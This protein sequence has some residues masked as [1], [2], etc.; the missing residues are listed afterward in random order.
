[1]LLVASFDSGY[2]LKIEPQKLDWILGVLESE[3][4]LGLPELLGQVV[5]QPPYDCLMMP[6][7]P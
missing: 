1:M 3:V 7:G 2:I 5:S 6:Y 4:S